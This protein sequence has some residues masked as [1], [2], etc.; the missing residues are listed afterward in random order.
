MDFLESPVLSLPWSSLQE[1]IWLI[2]NIIF[3]AVASW[4]LFGFSEAFAY[5]G[6]R[7]RQSLVPRIS[8]PTV[9]WVS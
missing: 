3:I 8:P 6:E 1:T 5:Y 2:V 9:S 4:L 7:I